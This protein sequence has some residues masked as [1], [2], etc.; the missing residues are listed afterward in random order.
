[1]NATI[2]QLKTIHIFSDLNAEVL[3]ELARSSEID[4]YQ[5]GE[6]LIHEGEKFPAKLHVIFCG[7]FLV[8]KIALSGKESNLRA[9]SSGEMFA[10][11][12]L[13]GDGIAPATVTALQDS[14][15]ITIDKSALIKTIQT[16]PEVALHILHYFNQRLQE[17]HQTIHGLISEKAVIRLARLIQYTA[18]QYGVQETKKGACLKARLPHQQMAR[19]VGITYEE[20][21]RIVKK[22]LATIILYERGGI[23]TIQDSSAFESLLF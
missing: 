1:M 19:M 3:A 23:I 9:L 2:Q 17:M 13:F 4:I 14:Q 22:E 6:V 10:A 21:V 5:Q 16:A 12:A 11:P 15:I 8:S 20:S 18:R 7:R